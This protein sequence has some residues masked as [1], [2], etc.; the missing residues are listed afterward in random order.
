MK[1]QDG[2]EICLGLGSKLYPGNMQRM[3]NKD[4]SRF[5]QSLS[6]ERQNRASKKK[7]VLEMCC[8]TSVFN[9]PSN[10]RKIWILSINQSN[11]KINKRTE[12]W[13]NQVAAIITAIKLLFSPI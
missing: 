5:M 13:P 3:L 8:V 4:L 11:V 9:K 12:Y 2:G 7:N 6:R 10:A 1:N